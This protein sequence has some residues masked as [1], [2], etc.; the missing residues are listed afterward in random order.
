[1]H[2]ICLKLNDRSS[3][4]SEDFEKINWL[5]IL[6]RVSQCSLCSIYKFF[7]KNCPNYFDEIDMIYVPL[8]TNGVRTGSSYQKLNAPHRKTNVGQ[9]ALSYV[10]SSFWNNFKKTWKT[11][12]GLNTFKHNIKQHHFNELKKKESYYQSFVLPMFQSK[13]I[14]FKF[15]I[16]MYYF[17]IFSSLPFLLKLIYFL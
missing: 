3:I 2:K 15:T 11:S 8:E 10:G 7:T 17:K 9:K 14:H 6:E 13:Y 1:M 12:T 16:Y 4:K 5:P